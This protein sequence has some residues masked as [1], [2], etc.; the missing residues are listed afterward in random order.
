MPSPFWSEP[1]HRQ[2]IAAED[3]ILRRL[4]NRFARRGL[5]QVV[6]T[7]H[8]L[9]RFRFRRLR[10]RHVHRHLVAVKVRVESRADERMNLNRAPLDQHHLESLNAQA[11]QRRC[12]VQQAPGDP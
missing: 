7:Q 5:E 10:Q 4:D 2:V 6:R 1:L 12:T 8:Q 3:H 11:V 9:P